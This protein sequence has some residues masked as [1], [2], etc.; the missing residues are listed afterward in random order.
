MCR[1]NEQ[2]MKSKEETFKT[3]LMLSP[4]QY[5]RYNYSFIQACFSGHVGFSDIYSRYTCSR[6]QFTT[7]EMRKKLFQVNFQKDFWDCHWKH[8][9]NWPIAGQRISND[10][11]TSLCKSKLSQGLFPHLKWQMGLALSILLKYC[12][13]CYK[14]EKLLG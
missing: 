1:N 8:G 2:Q 10:N 12:I 13:K 11:P 6:Y 4:C 14:L 9:K 3:S 7:L 5:C